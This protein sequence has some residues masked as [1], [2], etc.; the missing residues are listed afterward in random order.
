MKQ[1]SILRRKQMSKSYTPGLKVLKNAKIVKERLLPLKGNVL[2]KENDL[3]ESDSIVASTEIPGNVHMINIANELNIDVNQID[4]CMLV[5]V[6]ETIEKNQLIAQ[7]KGIFGMFKNDIKSPING[8]IIN[9]SNVTGQVVISEHPVPINV[10]AYVPGKIKDVYDKE[11][12][13]ITSIGTFVQGIIGI[14]GEK[15][16]EMIVLVDNCSDSVNISDISDDLKDKIIV[17]GSYIDID[18]YK[19]AKKI[20]IKGI[21]CGGVDYNTI[22][23][24][25]GYSLGVAITGTENTTTLILTEG[26]GQVNMAARTFR[27]LKD[28]N[29]KF[30]SINGAT[31]I[32]AGV[33][34]P[35]I[36]IKSEGSG[37]TKSISNQDL[38]ISEGSSVRVIREPYFGKIGK[39]V[40]LPYDLMTMKSE[41]KVRVAEVEFEDGLKE[42]IPRANLEVILS[43]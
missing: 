6:N 20:G 10:D 9:I 19:K 22:S 4:S 3:V 11:G 15:Q 27:I 1:M 14:G 30:V 16:G 35:E 13:L 38:I 43:N 36:F 29:K 41:T 17:C 18:L 7:S 33:L 25:L 39:I 31:Q 32:R 8:K 2:V 12:V 5:K 37:E 28:N 24:I 34:R 26:F 42:I 40:S 23:K 21:V